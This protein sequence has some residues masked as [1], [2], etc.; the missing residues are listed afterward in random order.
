MATKVSA[1]YSC[2]CYGVQQCK[3]KSFGKNMVYKLQFNNI[4][5]NMSVVY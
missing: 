2:C 4:G 1:A 3:E 5:K